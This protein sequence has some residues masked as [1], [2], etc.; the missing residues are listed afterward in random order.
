MKV[1][2]NNEIWMIGGGEFSPKVWVI[3]GNSNLEKDFDQVNGLIVP[4]GSSLYEYMKLVIDSQDRVIVPT[5]QSLVS[6]N[7]GTVIFELS[8]EEVSS[9]QELNIPYSEQIK[10]SPNPSKGQFQIELLSKMDYADTTIEVRNAMGQLIYSKVLGIIAHQELINV[11]LGEVAKGWYTISL[12]S[13][14]GTSS[15][16]LLIE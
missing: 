7:F 4:G 16:K 10:V 1:K 12:N 2:S 3:S 11:D 9:N 5:F 14:Q 6:A 8:L 15:Q 13:A